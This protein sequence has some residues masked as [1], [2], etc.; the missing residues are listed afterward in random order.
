[1]TD[2]KA[3]ADADIGGDLQ[4]AFE[5]LRD[6]TVSSYR[7]VTGNELRLWS[8][9]NSA[10]YSAIKAAAETNVIAE[11]AFSLIASPDSILE[12]DRADVRNMIDGL[13]G[14]GVM[15]DTGKTALLAMATVN[16][17][18]F[19]GLNQAILAKAR[20]MRAGGRV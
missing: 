18:Q 8:A 5:A 12:L 10:D 1:M 16:A 2:Y 20:D 4:T 14:A 11:I 3:I 13:V 7:A 19:P 15:S 9:S 17:P 6:Q